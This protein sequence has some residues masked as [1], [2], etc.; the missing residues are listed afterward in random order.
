[1]KKII[2]AS[3]N[4][5]KLN[6]T[7]EAFKMVF[8]DTDFD[9]KGVSVLSNV[10]DQP[11]SEKETMKGALNRVNNAFK[12]YKGADYWIGI[13]GGIQKYGKEMIAFAWVFI[14]DNKRIGK[15]RSA[16]FF[17]P[18]KIVDLINEGKEL[19]DADD[20]VFGKTNSKQKNGA[21]GILT[22]DI[23]TRTTYYIPPIILALIPFTN[24]ELY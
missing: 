7:L 18:N 9:I 4:P 21:V 17:L 22:K 3:H 16:S 1:M 15:G 11:R 14:R 24:K 5:V 20:I 2:V 8:K 6:A 19:G 12:Q 23:I 13:E 10:S